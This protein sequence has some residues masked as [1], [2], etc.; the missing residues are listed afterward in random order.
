MTTCGDDDGA[1]QT[2]AV[3]S[4]KHIRGD[5][6]HSQ[7]HAGPYGAGEILMT[8]A[9]TMTRRKLLVLMLLLT[10]QLWASTLGCRR[11]TFCCFAGAGVPKRTLGNPCLRL[12]LAGE[13][14][15]IRMQLLTAD[16]M[17]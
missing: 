12:F 3:N 16:S 6:E 9:S 11:R 1:M 15:R 10:A 13:E 4:P 14:L 17:I 8:S 2:D 5:D 7:E